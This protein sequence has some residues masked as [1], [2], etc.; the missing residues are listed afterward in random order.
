M[1]W[2]THALRNPRLA[3][4][5]AGTILV[6]V[7]LGDWRS[8]C[9]ESKAGCQLLFLSATLGQTGLIFICTKP[10]SGILLWMFDV[11]GVPQGGTYGRLGESQLGCRVDVSNCCSCLSTTAVF[12]FNVIDGSRVLKSV[13]LFLFFLRDPLTLCLPL[14]CPPTPTPK[15]PSRKEPAFVEAVDTIREACC[16]GFWRPVTIIVVV[17]FVLLNTMKV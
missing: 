6:E 1:P 13:F 8:S 10:F 4:V 5:C 15:P 11:A 7:C 16:H 12:L 17:F 14:T 3:E 9:L 2:G